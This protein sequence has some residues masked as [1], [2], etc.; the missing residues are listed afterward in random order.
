MSSD[1]AGE[2]DQLLMALKVLLEDSHYIPVTETAAH[3][4]A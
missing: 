1:G 3:N 2:V 4:I